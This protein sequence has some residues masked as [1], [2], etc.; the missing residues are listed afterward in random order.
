MVTRLQQSARAYW[1]DQ[2]A[3]FALQG[4]LTCWRGLGPCSGCDT[5]Q[6][7][8]P[9]ETINLRSISPDCQLQGSLN[10]AQRRKPPLHF[11]LL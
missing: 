11:L 7:T 8:A 3:V 4:L 1:R 6:W 2:T 9:L 10:P 5:Y